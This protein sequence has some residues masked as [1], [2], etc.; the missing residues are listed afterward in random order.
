MTDTQSEKVSVIIPA[1]NEEQHIA[2][3][4]KSVLHQTYPCEE[5]II[6]DDG[7]TDDTETIVKRFEDSSIRYIYQDNQG[8]CQTRNRAIEEAK[9]SLIA[10]LDADDFWMPEKMEK[11]IAQVKDHPESGM[12]YS[13]YR[14][15]D[16]EGEELPHRRQNRTTPSGWIFRDL[17]K[18]NVI[19]PSTTLI[20]K[21]CY[22]DVGMYNDDLQRCWDYEM[23]L[24]IALKYK[25]SGCSDQLSNYRIIEDRMSTNRKKSR[26]A[27]I[28]LLKNMYQSAK[29]T[30]Q[31]VSRKLLHKRLNKQYYKIARK[32][33]KKGNY[34][35]A[36]TFYQK[37]LGIKRLQPKTWIYTLMARSGVH[38]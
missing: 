17:F 15:V 27:I 34:E 9:Y 25:I 30:E 5:I 20:R 10:W 36:V 38:L 19:Q 23:W 2:Q 12:Y 6:L 11:Q 14:K 1:Y 13:D 4:I 26:G 24:R 29:G 35:E 16:H 3:S 31:E 22:E 28:K 8:V 21:E 18:R 37:S 7:S 32:Q 33:H